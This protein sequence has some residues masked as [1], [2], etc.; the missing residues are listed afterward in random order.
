MFQAIIYRWRMSLLT[1]R[2]IAQRTQAPLKTVRTWARRGYI[3][4]VACDVETRA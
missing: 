2:L 1:L 4:P 3:T